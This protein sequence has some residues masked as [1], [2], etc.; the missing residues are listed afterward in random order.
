[1]SL[2]IEGWHVF[3]EEVT[4][5]NMG[6]GSG[7]QVGSPSAPKALE[8]HRHQSSMTS[9]LHEHHSMLII[10]SCR[11]YREREREIERERERGQAKTNFK[12]HVILEE[13]I[14]KCKYCEE[15]YR[16]KHL[17]SKSLV[18]KGPLDRTGSDRCRPCTTLGLMWQRW[19]ERGHWPWLLQ[20]MRTPA[21]MR[22]EPVSSR[23]AMYAGHVRSLPTR[24]SLFQPDV[25]KTPIRCDSADSGD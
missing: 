18:V 5:T 3:G 11:A 2:T 14:F 23:L 9:P 15:L 4:F 24:P 6:W 25:W 7:A 13:A 21:A 10:A 16:G 8:S 17:S 12:A 22:L 20:S 1:M 19:Q